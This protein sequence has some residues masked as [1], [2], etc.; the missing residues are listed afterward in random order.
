MLAGL[1][2]RIVPKPMLA[3]K[4]TA[5]AL[6]CM[7]FHFVGSAS[8]T[9]VANGM[10]LVVLVYYTAKMSG[11]HLNP[12]A[13]LAFMLLG[14][15]TPAE[16]LLYW[17]MQIGG[18]LCGALLLSAL[19]PGLA[20][21]GD[22]GFETSGCFLTH[23]DVSSSQVVGWEAA[24]TFCF[25][26]PVFSVVWYTQSKSGYGNTGPI[27]VGLSLLAS[28][29]AVG[30]WTGAALNPARVLGSHLVF[31]CPGKHASGSHYVLGQLIGGALVPLAIAPWYGC[32][33]EPWW[34]SQVSST[35]A[36]E[37]AAASD[38]D[39][40]LTYRC[41]IPTRRLLQQDDANASVVV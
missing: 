39:A 8:P 13:S 26:V 1:I 28:A 20:V 36:D 31:D 11:G 12:A 41:R 29:L 24:G 40:A 16:M 30:P 15:L 22:G 21:G 34:K 7:I 37:D 25:L 10:V 9:P 27:I 14:H 3:T 17:A 35:S 4:L 5:E 38:A 32:A 18:C 19:V 6:G 2:R 33:S 23:P